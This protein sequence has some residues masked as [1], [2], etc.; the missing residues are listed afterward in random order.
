MHNYEDS[1]CEAIEYIVEHAISQADFDKTIQATIVECIDKSVGKYKVKYQDSNFYAYSNNINVSYSKG[2]SVYV[3]VPKN[4]MSNMKTI[5]GTIEALGI[6]YLDSVEQDSSYSL[7]GKNLI[8]KKDSY[9]LCSYKKAEEV[10]LYDRNSNINLINLNLTGVQEYIFRADLLICKMKIQTKL[11]SEQKYHGNYGMNVEL[12]FGNASSNDIV[13]KNYIVDI[14]QMTGNP[15]QFANPTL[16]YGIFNIDKDNF[17]YINKISLFEYNFPNQAEDK[18]NDLFF[19]S[20]ELLGANSISEAELNSYYLNLITEDGTYFTDDDE[21]NKKLSIKADVVLKGNSV[22]TTTQKIEFYWF[23]A[24]TNILTNSVKYNQY[25]G[26]GWECLNEYNIIQNS[27]EN[28]DALISWIPGNSLLEIQKS[29]IVAAYNN[30]KCVAVYNN[31][32]LKQ[33]V[34]IS[35]KSS[36]YNITIESDGGNVFYY[37]V[38]SSNLTCKINGAESTENLTYTWG[39]ETSD[40]QYD[41][42]EETTLNNNTLKNYNELYDRLLEQ[43][44]NEEVLPAAAELKLANYKKQIT[45]LESKT[46]VENNK[47]LHLDVSEISK[48]NIYRC[49]VYKDNM[50][51]GTGSIVIYNS[52]ENVTGYTLEINNGNQI[53]NYS[54][55]GISPTSTSNIKRQEIKPLSFTIYNSDGAEI[56][57]KILDKCIIQWIV[58]VEN[59]MLKVDDD[60]NSPTLDFKL[61]DLYR[62][63]A[64]NN[65]IQLRVT[66]QDYLLIQS[67]NFTF[68]KQGEN[69]TNGTDVVCKIVPNVKDGE[70]TPPYPMV[71]KRENNII[72]NFTPK[73]EGKYF[74]VQ[75]WENSELVFDD[76]VSNEET[77]VKWSILQNNYSI[78]ASKL[79][80]PSNFVVDNSGTFSYND[81]DTDCPA[82]IIKCTVTK[83]GMTYYA[84]LP[85]ITAKI[86]DGDYIFNLK[87][88]TGFLN[89]LYS[90]TGQFPQYNNNLPFELQIMR[91]ID[92]YLEDVTLLT[93]DRYRLS[94]IW[95]SVGRIY[96]DEWKNSLS[97]KV[98]NYEKNKCTVIPENTYDGNCVTNGIQCLVVHE[99]DSAI[100]G[101]IHIPVQMQ[102][103]RYSNLAIDS[104]DGNSVSVDEDGSGVILAPQ[105]GAGVK[106]ED[107]TF[108]GILM[109]TV[110]EYGSPKKEGLFGYNHGE[111]TIKLDAE[112]GSAAFGKK[113]S[114]QIIIDPNTDVSML[115][116]YNFWKAYNDYGKPLSYGEINYNT[117]GLLIDLTTPQIRFG[118]GNFYIGADGIIH[119][120]GAVLE[121]YATENDVETIVQTKIDDTGLVS[122]VTKLQTD[123]SNLQNNIENITTLEIFLLNENIF[124]PTD[125]EGNNGDYSKAST[126]VSVYLGSENV[127]A[128]S[129]YTVTANADVI[130]TWDETNKKYTITGLKADSGY[131][132]FQ[133]NYEERTATKRLTITKA[134]AGKQGEDGTPGKDGT[135]GEGAKTVE[136]IPS[137]QIFKSTD[138]GKTFSPDS[139][140]LTSRLQNVT[141]KKWSYSLDGGTTWNDVINNSHGFIISSNILLIS[142]DSDLFTSTIT[143]ISFKCETEDDTVYNIITIA[144]LYD[145]TELEIGGRNLILN[146]NFY[147]KFTNWGYNNVSYTIVEDIEYGHYLK[148]AATDS[149]TSKIYSN[150]SQVW[151]K[152]QIYS[153]SFYAKAVNTQTLQASRDLI[154]KGEIHV[155]S[156]TW[157]RFTGVINCTETDSTGTLSF[158]IGQKNVETYIA[159]VK[160]ETGDV[161]TAWTPAPEDFYNKT[162]V[163]SNIKQS[164][165][166]ITSTVNQKFMN[167]STTTEV[168][169]AIKQSSD[170]ILQQVKAVGDI[171]KTISGTGTLNIESAMEGQLI[172]LH[173]YGGDDS[174]TFLYPSDTLYPSDD[175][176]PM[177][178]SFIIV[179]DSNNNSV[180]YN[181]NITDTLRKNG[182]IKD[183]FILKNNQAQL[184]RR[185][186]RDDNS[187]LQTE[188]VEDLGEFYINL[189]E[190]NNTI[191][192]KNSNSEMECTFVFLNNFTDVFSTKADVNSQIKLTQKEFEVAINTATDSENLISKINLNQTSATIEAKNINLNG[193]VTANNNF[194][195]LEDGSMEA[196]NGTFSGDIILGSGGKVVGGDGL[197][198]NLFY[199]SSGRYMG[200]DLLGF[201][202]TIASDGITLSGYRKAI[203]LD[204]PIP[205][206]FKIESAILTLEHTPAV[207]DGYDDTLGTDFSVNGY[208][209]N[210]KLYK[211]FS[212]YS[213]YMA[214]FSEPVLNTASLS[215]TEIPSAFGSSSYTPTKTSG[216]TIELKSTIDI[217]NY[218][219]QGINKLYIQTTEGL[220][221]AS[222]KAGAEKT[223][224]ARAYINVIGYLNYIN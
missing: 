118:N 213:F 139:I 37:D 73:K 12:A 11:P 168:N 45:L 166:S 222:I 169:T 111:Q 5:L 21:D 97:L 85:I 183:E 200:Y 104:W 13:L 28:Q 29:D 164:A 197:K 71:T 176:Y 10:V 216:N 148:F 23:K 52:N 224:M 68:V 67:T 205:Q 207:W 120:K 160:L 24:N 38:G 19:S 8:E 50:Y 22:D 41:I 54:E 155:L 70:E 72:W 179:T 193:V 43:V 172:E 77:K 59:T 57:D 82:N 101:S 98:K 144:K 184:I 51:L 34:V 91:L 219:T 106:N 83:N 186:N 47:I 27:T 143:S 90:S 157:Q 108:T 65:Q 53:F 9:E 100:I 195:I 94:Y 199:S 211:G 158:E 154:D 153:Y 33:T 95:K 40:G 63:D 162:Q 55:T 64:Y 7:I 115:Y 177:G 89:V 147:N 35:N 1:I 161:A 208:S 132:D 150:V 127:T 14:D 141:F 76:V 152:G 188:Q 81:F 223:G 48:Y 218:L 131:V 93:S 136:I 30:Y 17:K 49:T 36:A 185:I 189:T 156:N 165:D 86:N 69:G 92:N 46:R 126:T 15:Y 178:D 66:Y 201:D 206:N 20:L 192:T 174:F 114:G 122:S 209:R 170:E 61:A 198:T 217:K 107:N 194:K 119:A 6:D 215:L 134:K 214:Y 159:N 167:Y 80:D 25:G 3:L 204:V 84:T 130:G 173:I 121:G 212:N 74:K 133:A 180:E 221:G 102:L 151:K 56:Q 129:N 187:V 190:G 113:G 175:L 125:Y 2:T 142:K 44:K 32:V 112:D 140:A 196:M 171:T 105:V 117:E 26:R 18:E 182:E 103:N 110:K 181:L 146:S 124:I 210:L 99:S 138:G 163:D 109:G 78:S 116:S 79:T 149:N 75:L 42:L 128:R 31:I 62:T 60:L 16:Q 87:D 123:V 220:P 96:D 191:T 58:P 145:I 135:P 4:D 203:S 39:V 88:N 137:A 202:F